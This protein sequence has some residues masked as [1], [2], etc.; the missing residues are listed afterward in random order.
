[1]VN[2]KRKYFFRQ[3]YAQIISDISLYYVWNEVFMLVYVYL[4]MQF[5]TV[6]H[7]PI[8][9]YDYTMKRNKHGNDQRYL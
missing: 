7:G 6:I 3:N 9:Y 4:S 8:F 1:M 5:H 2:L